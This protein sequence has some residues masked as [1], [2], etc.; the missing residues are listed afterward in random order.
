VLRVVVDHVAPGEIAIEGEPAHYVA[1]VH[2]VARGDRIILVDPTR[3]VEAV[4]LVTQVSQTAV[5]CEVGPTRPSAKV[6][7][8][9]LVLIQSIAK[10]NKVDAIVRDATELGA[11]RIVIAQAARSIVK[12]DLKADARQ[13]RWRRIAREA[14]R[15]CGRGDAPTVDGPMQWSEAV[16]TDAGDA[17]LKICLWE[18]AV[19]PIG[20][21]LGGL[22][23]GQPVAFAI[24]PEGGLLAAEVEIAR[25]AGFMPVTMGPFVLRTE[26]VAPSLLGALLVLGL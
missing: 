15:Q 22:R 2:R 21:H 23:P 17:A 13:E 10:G 12:L 8:R 9:P 16:R 5:R 20:P 7:S 24:G 4:A 19:D 6:A 14:A 11:T 1:R 18:E 25:T 26:T 3:A